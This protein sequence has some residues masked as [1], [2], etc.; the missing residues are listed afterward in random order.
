MI[1]SD[2]EALLNVQSCDHSKPLFQ[3]VFHREPSKAM[4][5]HD[6]SPPTRRTGEKKNNTKQQGSHAHRR[7]EGRQPCGHV[8]RGSKV[9]IRNGCVYMCDLCAP[10][11]ATVA[12]GLQ[13]GQFGRFTIVNYECRMPME[14]RSAV[15]DTAH[16]R[17]RPDCCMRK[18]FRMCKVVARSIVDD[19]W[20]LKVMTRNNMCA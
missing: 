18:V 3:T 4:Q 13:G 1:R 20:R 16:V 10:C 17:Q 9:L 5:S 12:L 7:Q 15:N 6:G 14:L 8:F 2:Y 11:K 19:F